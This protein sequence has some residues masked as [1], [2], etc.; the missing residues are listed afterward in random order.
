MP[1]GAGGMSLVR[2]RAA[3]VAA[4]VAACI[5]FAPALRAPFQFDDLDTIAGNVSIRRLWPPSV[6]LS[7]PADIATTGRPVVNYTFA[8]NYALNDWL[9]LNQAADAN[10]PAVTFGFHAVNLLLHLLCGAL[11][12][13]LVRR[14]LRAPPLAAEWAAVADGLAAAVSALWL[15]H[16]LQTEAVDYVTQRTELLVSVFYLA[17]LYAAVRAWESGTARSR[18][19]W[20]VAAVAACVAGMGS[21]E[22]M[23]TAP[24]AVFLHDRAFAA[25]SWSPAPASAAERRTFYTLLWATAALGAY[26]IVTG[27]RAETVGFHLGVPWYRYLYSQA[28][29]IAHYLRLSVWPSALVIDYGQDPIGGLR[30]VPGALLLATLLAGTVVAWRRSPPLAFA[31]A[32]FF[33][34]LAPSSSVVPIRTEIAAERRFYLALGIVLTVAAMAVVHGVRQ[35][36][37]APAGDW[38]RRAAGVARQWW[39]VPAL[40]LMCAGLTYRRSRTYTDPVAMWRGAVAA[41]PGNARAHHNLARALLYAE[42]PRADEAEAELRRAIAADSTYLPAWPNLASVLAVQGHQAEARR[43]LEHAV[44]AD[45]DYAAAL[46]GLG[47]LLVGMGENAAAVAPLERLTARYPSDEGFVAL[48]T[49]YGS[50]GRA[51]DAIAALRRARQLNPGRADAAGYLAAALTGRGQALAVAGD[52]AGVARARALLEEALG[53]RPDFAPAREA[54]ARLGPSRP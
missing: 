32:W 29:A 40:C 3:L 48:A 37:R 31:G 41:V 22:V 12:F 39:V 26:A 28:W 10:D 14:T 9:G 19:R 21:K 38:R 18:R 53:V 15:L 16:P 13:G 33:L 11:L 2:A 44:A 35:M 52:S 50:L 1:R 42:P 36:S 17:T 4:A 45:S 47:Y 23:I 49:A 34:L 7:P 5:A 20:F 6:P 24:L 30:P 43:L 8:L 25:Q 27:A 46:S 54:L 51:D